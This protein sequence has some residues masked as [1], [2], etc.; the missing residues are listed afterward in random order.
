[1][2]WVYLLLA[3]CFEVGFTTC[4]RLADGFKHLGWSGAFVGCAVLSFTFLDLAQRTLPLGLAYAV[5]V[6][7][8]AAGTAIVGNL[9]FGE[10]LGLV[11]LIFIGGIIACVVGLKVASPH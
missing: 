5:W 2:A 10:R 11:P 8:G 7:I 4:L 9:Y 6:G 3:A 1:M